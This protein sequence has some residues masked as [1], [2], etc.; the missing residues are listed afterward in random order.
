MRVL[1]L[2]DN[3]LRHEV[4]GKKLRPKCA[5]LVQVRTCDEACKAMEDMDFDVMY[6][7]HNL[8][9]FMRVASGCVERTGVDVV[10]YILQ[11]L[12]EARLPRMV[13]ITSWNVEGA[14]RMRTLLRAANIEVKIEPFKIESW[15]EE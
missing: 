10:R 14:Q 6:L 8:G 12:G 9:D 11:H 3:E 4:M 2:D 5:K 13:V 7:D 15:W 1:I